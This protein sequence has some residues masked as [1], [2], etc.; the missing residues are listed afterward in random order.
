MDSS[1]K[2][3]LGILLAIVAGLIGCGMKLLYDYRSPPAVVYQLDE[4]AD[5]NGVV[6]ESFSTEKETEIDSEITG[7]QNDVDLQEYIPVY[8]CGAVSSPGVYQVCANS[9]LYEL[10]EQAG[11]FTQD[12]A[13]DCINLVMQFETPV[14]V[15]IPTDMEWDSSIG[16]DKLEQAS[17]Y[18]RTSADEYVWG[19]KNTGDV[20]ENASED[21]NNL[22]N[23]NS[24]DMTELM[25]IPGIG[26]VMAMA[27][28]NYRDNNEPFEKIEDIMNVSGIKQGRFDAMK[29]TITI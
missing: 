7:N 11:G 22:V 13:T 19:N 23:I 14:S 2:K 29:D 12:A 16:I 9:F 3:T 10:V 17:F 24:A 4:V 18:M 21:T 27:I 5:E 28:M 6:S 1:K 8:I 26:E 25:T 20:S 15:Y